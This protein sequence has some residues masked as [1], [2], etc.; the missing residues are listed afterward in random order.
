MN[1]SMSVDSGAR[2]GDSPKLKHSSLSGIPGGTPERD[3]LSQRHRL[4]GWPFGSVS[5]SG[6]PLPLLPALGSQPDV[7]KS[8]V[9]V[10]D[11]AGDTGRQIGAQ[12]RSG[13][14]DVVNGHVAP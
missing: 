13:I 14:A 3:G 8:C 9:D 12:E 7:A 11:L 6:S 10:G 5:Q 1:D 2:A 4:V